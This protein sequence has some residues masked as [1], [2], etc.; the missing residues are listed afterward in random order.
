MLKGE[1]LIQD[2]VR[3]SLYSLKDLQYFESNAEHWQELSELARRAEEVADRWREARLARPSQVENLIDRAYD[4]R[5][6]ILEARERAGLAGCMVLA[7]TG[8]SPDDWPRE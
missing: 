3:Q 6:T 7:L 5:V 1:A 2:Q 8:V 4:A